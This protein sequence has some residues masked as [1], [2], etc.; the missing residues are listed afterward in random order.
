MSS[1][2]D[3]LDYQCRHASLLAYQT[4]EQRRDCALSIS[5][6]KTRSPFRGPSVF[7]RL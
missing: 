7:A 4:T 5:G 1:K 6:K 2:K 3:P